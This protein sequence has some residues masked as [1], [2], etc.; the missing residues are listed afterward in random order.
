MIDFFV[1]V[2]SLFR[3]GLALFALQLEGMLDWEEAHI[4]DSNVSPGVQAIFAAMVMGAYVALENLAGDLWEEA[5][6][7]EG[8]ALL[9]LDA[10]EQRQAVW[11]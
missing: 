4:V 9:K 8:R 1:R 2:L 3:P 10:K 11:I 7:Q 5:L 6:K